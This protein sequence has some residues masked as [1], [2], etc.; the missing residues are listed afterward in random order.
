MR[1]IRGETECGSYAQLIVEKTV[2]TAIV[3]ASWWKK[4]HR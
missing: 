3:T 2:E 4:C 1:T